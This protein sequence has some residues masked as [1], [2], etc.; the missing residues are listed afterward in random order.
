MNKLQQIPGGLLFAIR[1]VFLIAHILLG[2]LLGVV[3]I[4][5]PWSGAIRFRKRRSLIRWWLGTS[6][7]LMGCRVTLNGDQSQI[8]QGCL[9]ISNHISWLDILV[10]GGAFGTRFLSKQEVRHWPV[11]G[12]LSTLNGTLFIQRG[13][14]AAQGV[15]EIQQ[16]I[17]DG[18]RIL[19]FPEGTTGLGD[20][21]K[22]FHPR[23]LKSAIEIGAPIQPVMLTYPLRHNG[24]METNTAIGWPLE[25]SMFDTLWA[26]LSRWNTEAVVQLLPVALT[27][28]ELPRK[29]L[30]K[31]LHQSVDQARQNFYHSS[32]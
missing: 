26:L 12:W 21:V 32:Q 23:M 24:Y 22:P 29:E 18:D 6:A 8:P 10:L 16:A 7:R 11:V 20:H 31:Q 19:M 14:G 5:R 4:W 9:L 25:R 3:F 17:H 30:A 1:I 27:E 28:P 13:A 15:A 2:V